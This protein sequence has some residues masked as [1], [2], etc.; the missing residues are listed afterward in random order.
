MT[1]V[2]TPSQQATLD[3]SSHLAVT[4]NAG[5]GKTSVLARRFVEI[6]LRTD[7]KLSEVVAITFTEQAAGEL[8]KKIH[9]VIIGRERDPALR[10][11]ERQR[12]VNLRNQLSSAVIGTIHSFCA[13]TLRMYP[14]E[15]DI[16]A[17]FTIV[18]GQERA[19]LIGESI[20]ETFS[21]FMGRRD[22]TGREGGFRDL[23][24]AVPPAKLERFLQRMFSQREQLYRRY[25]SLSSLSSPSSL[26]NAAPPAGHRGGDDGGRNAAIVS[27][28]VA[29]AIESDWNG[30]ARETAAA[31]SG[32]D[33]AK[34]AALLGAPGFSPDPA[35]METILVEAGEAMFLKSGDFRVSFLGSTPAES[36]PREPAEYLR[37]FE[38]RYGRLLR[39]MGSV[40]AREMD[41]RYGRLLDTLEKVFISARDRYDAKKEEAG[42]LDFEDLQIRT[43]ELLD[44]DGVRERLRFDYKFFLVDEFQDTNDLQYSILKG[45]L[46]NFRS[47]NLF[48]VGDPKQS[49]YGFR[50]A[51]VGVF[52][53]ARRDIAAEV[54]KNSG[55][56][57]DGSVVLAESF[58]PLPEI[59]AF[60]NVIFSALMKRGGSRHEVDYDSIVSG[61]SS[62]TRGSVGML[63]VPSGPE[64]GRAAALREECELV[65]RRLDAIAGGGGEKGYSYGQCAVLLRDRTNLPALEKAFEEAGIPYLLAGGVGFFQTQEI[66]DFLNYLR[67]LVSPDDDPA[68]A[69]V[70]RSPFFGLSDEDLLGIAMS[71][72]ISL[73]EKLYRFAADPLS[74]LS[75][76]RARELLAA[77]RILADRIPVPRLLRRIAADTGW[78]GTMAGLSHGPQHRENFLKLLELARKRGTGGPFTLYDFSAYLDHRAE[79]EEREGQAATG[80][81]GKAVRVMTVHAAKGLEFPVVLLPFLDRG[82]WPDHDPIIH[83]EFG[84]GFRVAG[85]GDVRGEAAPMHAFL[86]AVSDEKRNAEE[87]RVFY[88]ACTRARDVLI[89]SGTEKE[90]P[91]RSSP[92]GWLMGIIGSAGI[93]ERDS[94]LDFGAV[95]VRCLDPGGDGTVYR[96]R[97]VALSVNITRPAASDT[98]GADRRPAPGSRQ[99]RPSP[100][101]LSAPLMDTRGGETYSATQLKTFM[102]CPVQYYLAYVLGVGGGDSRRRPDDGFEDE[103]R[104]G[105]MGAA[106]LEG[107]IT[108]RVLSELDA[109]EPE[110][111]LA[112]RISA[113]VRTLRAGPGASRLEARVLENVSAF[114]RSPAGRTILPRPGARTEYQISAL[115]G[116]AVVMGKIDRL[117]QGEDGL[118]EFVDYK[119]DGITPAEMA[120]RAREHKP[121]LAIYAY[122]VSRLCVQSVVRGSLLF[123]KLGSA[124]VT[125]D[126]GVGEFSAVEKSLTGSI[127]AIRRGIFTP[128]TVPCRGCPSADGKV[129]GVV[130][131]IP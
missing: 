1:L 128:P 92:L 8:R 22:G 79:E 103:W 77:H 55:G 131:A 125:F 108:H 11:G 58:R 32:K 64:K 123:L 106:A 121:Q 34:I 115:V 84:I 5:A 81:A 54:K 122:L 17:S 14:A 130:P 67:F 112:A 86:K 50:N 71:A 26:S 88:V 127:D 40:D 66:Y 74:P 36:L 93:A 76:R 118:V 3:L 39:S 51:E 59:A 116:D 82:T 38:S 57:G 117:F 21:E 9:D 110:A 83:P 65:A 41:R 16:D 72:G 104:G 29:R 120:S 85:E 68:L 25:S 94:A 35:R 18:E 12:L 89:L 20:A 4:A 47:G 56:G 87:K 73:W 15:A 97:N 91:V 42:L 7:A 119:T 101:I 52:Y 49:I 75:V 60:V 105:G 96:D 53:D 19:R 98:V 10:A 27:A 102:E 114:L 44:R 109:A 6:F 24:R 111:S 45:F 63:L 46:G 28:I 80:A 126:F 62:S 90:K 78:L 95:A 70:L 48:I 33:A 23:L 43:L 107:D 37:E 13:R 61:R 2:L 113:L 31:A 99:P 129:C 30:R 124:P 100:R 69:G